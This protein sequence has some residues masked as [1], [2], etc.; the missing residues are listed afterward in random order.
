MITFNGVYFFVQY[1]GK[2]EI[3]RMTTVSA[4]LD[5]KTETNI[6]DRQLLSLGHAQCSQKDNFNRKEGRKLATSRCLTGLSWDKETKR[7]FWEKYIEKFGV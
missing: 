6:E 7:K 5:E 3:E 1:E 2:E 4:V